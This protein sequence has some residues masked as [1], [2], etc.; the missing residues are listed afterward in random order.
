MGYT[1]VRTDFVVDFAACRV[2]DRGSF[3]DVGADFG[4][5]WKFTNNEAKPNLDPAKSLGSRLH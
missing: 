5:V 3:N 2:E 4:C 1:D